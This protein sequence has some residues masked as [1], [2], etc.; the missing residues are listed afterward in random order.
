MSNWYKTASEGYQTGWT[1]QFGDMQRYIYDA[2]EARV[3]ITKTA[4]KVT[5]SVSMSHQMYGHTMWQDFWLFEIAEESKA[6]TTFAEVKKIT[7]QVFEDFR[8]NEIPNPMLHSFLRE[9]VRHISEENKPTS[10][11]PYVDWAK[12]QDGVSDWRSSIYGTRYPTEH[13]EGF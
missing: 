10:R 13:T 6:K 1:D 3:F 8:T 9:A 12:K 7:H 2:Y 11:I 5:V 4:K